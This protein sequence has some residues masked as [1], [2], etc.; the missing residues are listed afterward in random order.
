MITD[1]IEYLQIVLGHHL[2]N[3]F[4]PRFKTLPAKITTLCFISNDIFLFEQFF[5]LLSLEHHTGYSCR[6]SSNIFSLPAPFR[7]SVYTTPI[8]MLNY[9]LPEQKSIWKKRLLSEKIDMTTIHLMRLLHP[10][11]YRP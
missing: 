3:L 10:S 6:D 9:Q 2:L 7:V 8:L 11:F 4:T 5:F 1:K